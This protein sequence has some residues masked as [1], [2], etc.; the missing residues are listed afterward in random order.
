MQTNLGSS[1]WIYFF[2]MGLI[3]KKIFLVKCY[4]IFVPGKAI[5]NFSYTKKTMKAN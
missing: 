1:F 4:A 3:F 5:A 2:F